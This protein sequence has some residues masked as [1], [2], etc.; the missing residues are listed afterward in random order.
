M[1]TGSRSYSSAVRTD[2]ARAT[3][4]RILAAAHELFVADG[5]TGTTLGAVAKAAGVSLQTLY[6]SVGNKAAL[7]TAVYDVTLAGDDDP[8]PIAQR[9]GIQA[10]FAAPDA[11][12]CLARYAAVGRELGER[13]VPLVAVIL[14]ESGNPDI[15]ALARVTEEQRLQGATA[16]VA[17]V[18][19]RFELR[20]GLTIDRARD[21][22]WALT[23]PDTAIRLVMRQGWS[24]DDYEAWLAD[25]MV[26]LLL[27]P[28]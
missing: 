16:T 5:Y 15:A 14:A 2:Q 4:R 17:H 20:P 22:L 10:V 3:R 21:S 18:A 26:R 24:W 8:V 11:P 6:N 25:A 7:L 27:P 23:A 1:S 13:A 12:T 19:E 9:P 28:A